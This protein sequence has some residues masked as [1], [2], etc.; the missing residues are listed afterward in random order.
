MRKISTICFVILILISLSPWQSHS[1][2]MNIPV[3]KQHPE[4]PHGCEI[5][6]LAATLKFLGQDISKVELAK[7]YL[8]HKEFYIKNKKLY[9]ADPM[10]YYVGSPWKQSGWFCY[11]PPIVS[12][13]NKYFS[14]KE[15]PYVAVDFSKKTEQD[16]RK[17]IANGNPILI[18]TTRDLHYVKNIRKWHFENTH[19]THP[20]PINLHCVVLRGFEND[21]VHYMDPITANQSADVRKFFNRYLHLGSHAVLIQ[22][23]NLPIF[24]NLSF[25]A[26][27]SAFMMLKNE[28]YEPIESEPNFAQLIVS[29]EYFAKVSKVDVTQN[30]ERF[31]LSNPTHRLELSLNSSSATLDGQEI[32]LAHPTLQIDDKIYISL[33]DIAT[34]FDISIVK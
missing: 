7:N 27:P 5:T 9:G 18:W 21:K 2:M 19:K 11:A 10:Q 12:A 31:I 6:S 4:L 32:A 22:K 23:N 30:N 34:Q 24:T 17:E 16:F 1:E 8:P 25:S 3:V 14:E 15:L 26:N 28:R 33:L 29:L 20:V 13:A